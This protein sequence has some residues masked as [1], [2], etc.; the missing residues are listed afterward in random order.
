MIRISGCEF[1]NAGTSPM[2]DL[3]GCSG[4]NAIRISE[5]TFEACDRAIQ[6]TNADRVG[7]LD[8]FF[9]GSGEVYVQSSSDVEIRSNDMW[10]ADDESI[11]VASGS[12]INIVGNRIVD[13]GGHNIRLSN[14]THCQVEDNT[15]RWAG[16]TSNTYDGILLEG[17]SDFNN[18]R[19]NT[20]VPFNSGASV[21][22]YG[23]NISDAACGCN[24]V[25]DNDFG[26]DGSL[27]GTDALNNASSST[28][29]TFQSDPTYGDNWIGCPPA[30]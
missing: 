5:N 15:I 3:S 21:P 26:I 10:S 1:E 18:I 2:I 25:I 29:L 30:S 27:Y 12:R 11:V 17:N 23:I 22:R 28:A 9:V 4:A 8:N 6:V 13:G 16:D 20:L 14:A 19:G 24:R 7:I